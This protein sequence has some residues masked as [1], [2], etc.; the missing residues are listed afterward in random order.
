LPFIA[1]SPTIYFSAAPKDSVWKVELALDEA[2]TAVD[3]GEIVDGKTIML[4]QHLALRELTEQG[5]R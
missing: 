4:L 1:R 2:L 5:A 3:R